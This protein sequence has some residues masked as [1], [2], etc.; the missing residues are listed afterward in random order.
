MRPMR[1]SKYKRDKQGKNL[2]SENTPIFAT[3]ISSHP[4]VIQ[5][6]IQSLL[7]TQKK[8]LNKVDIKSDR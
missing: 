7:C 6:Q 4:Y 1:P 3:T 8:F 2:T 5:E